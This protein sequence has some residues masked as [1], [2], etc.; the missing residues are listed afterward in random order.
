M[1][2]VTAYKLQYASD[3]SAYALAI[4]H[5]PSVSTKEKFEAVCNANLP[6]FDKLAKEMQRKC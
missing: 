6:E 4:W 1:D 2:P 5:V 3:P